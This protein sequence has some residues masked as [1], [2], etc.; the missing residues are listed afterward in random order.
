MGLACH[1]CAQSLVAV[2]PGAPE[3]IYLLVG[4]LLDFP[5]M[6]MENPNYLKNTKYVEERATDLI[7]VLLA[8]AGLPSKPN[9]VKI[10]YNTQDSSVPVGTD[11]EPANASVNI[12]H[13][14]V[15]GLEMLGGFKLPSWFSLKAT[16]ISGTTAGQVYACAVLNFF[17]FKSGV[18]RTIRF[19]LYEA[20][21]Y[22]GNSPT[23]IAKIHAGPFPGGKMHVAYMPVF[24]PALTQ[25]RM[26]HIRNFA[27]NAPP[28][29]T[30]LF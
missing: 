6:G 22:M 18:N 14:E 28:S 2:T 5:W 12:V 19:P 30:D 3:T 11:T 25:G 16:G 7:E 26:T 15:T 17:D 9:Q 1:V 20:T 8:K 10:V 23:P 4:M 24:N 29:S 27:L 13:I 21:N